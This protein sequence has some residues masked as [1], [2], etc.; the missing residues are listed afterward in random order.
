VSPIQSTISQFNSEPTTSSPN[1]SHSE[2]L[3]ENLN[4]CQYYLDIDN[5]Y[6]CI[7]DYNYPA[8]SPHETLSIDNIDASV[9]KVFYRNCVL[10]YIPSS[11]F[12]RFPNMKYLSISNTSLNALDA[13]TLYG[14]GNVAYL[15][16]SFNNIL[17]L[18]AEYVSNCK[19]LK[20]IDLTGVPITSIDANLINVLPYLDKVLLNNI[21]E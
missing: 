13:Q 1:N 9:A 14:C 5:H 19:N 17:E 7:F 8:S 12:Q 11:I 18:K 6:A 16:L 3:C 20:Y 2:I 21:Y 10:K 4:I 15:D